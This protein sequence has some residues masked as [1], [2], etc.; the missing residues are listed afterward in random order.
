MTASRILVIVQARLGSLRMPGK[1]RERIGEFS[2]LSHVVMRARCAL[3][4]ARIVVAT[5]TKDAEVLRNAIPVG[6]AEWFGWGGHE[7]D[8]LGRFAAAA[9]SPQENTGCIVRLT[10]DCPFVG[11]DGIAAVAHAVYSGTAQ[12]A[13]TGGQVN[14]LDAEAFTPELLTLAHRRATSA[15]DREHVT[16]WMRRLAH[17]RRVYRYGGYDHL[18]P[19]LWAMDDPAD[20]AWARA[21]ARLINTTPPNPSPERLHALIVA[22]PELRRLRSEPSMIVTDPDRMPE[23]ASENYDG[24]YDAP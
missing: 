20:L 8:V 17:E 10:A 13:R 24:P 11:L 3:P 1:V 23:E 5:P 15:Y 21:M 19:Y 16:S 7:A 18:P 6:D 2:I 12:Y 22:H 9:Y 4:H 14:G